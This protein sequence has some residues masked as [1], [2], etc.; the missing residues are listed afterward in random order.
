M[1]RPTIDHVDHTAV[2][3]RVLARDTDPDYHLVARIIDRLA[4]LDGEIRDAER[5]RSLPGAS[6]IHVLGGSSDGVEGHLHDPLL[7][8]LRRLRRD[9]RRHLGMLEDGIRC[10]QC[11][12]RF[13]TGWAQDEAEV[14]RLADLHTA[15]G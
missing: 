7:R 4:W 15:V 10:T 11:R 5:A 8:E 13:T 6:D 3:V 1:T 14:A 9:W 2:L 12:V